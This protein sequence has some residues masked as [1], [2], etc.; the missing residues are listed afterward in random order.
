[1]SDLSGK[2]QT[3][4]VDPSTFGWQAHQAL[5]AWTSSV[6]TKASIALVVE[7]AVAATATHALIAKT[8][9]LHSSRALQ[10]ANAITALAALV[11]AVGCALWVIFP[12]LSR[13][14]ALRAPLKGLIFFGHL[15]VQ[16]RE[17]ILAALKSLTTRDELL[18][19]AAQLE[20]PRR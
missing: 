2:S 6:D 16:S 19:L 10:L 11:V 14:Q 3:D 15:R 18:E 5:Q 20:A 7:V 9:E 1:M 8:G 4:P 13:H 12:R 17:T